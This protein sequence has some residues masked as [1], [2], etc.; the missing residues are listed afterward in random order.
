MVVVVVEVV[1]EVG[2]VVEVEVGVVVGVVVEVEVVVGINGLVF[3]SL[4]RKEPP[5]QRHKHPCS[6][7]CR[8][9]RKRC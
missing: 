7:P 3:D 5:C 1:V 9:H 4:T 6:N 2:V 8:Q